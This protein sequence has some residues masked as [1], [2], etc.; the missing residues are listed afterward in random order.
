VVEASH[1]EL[2]LQGPLTAITA[3]LVGV[4]ANLALFFAGPLLWPQGAIGP[5]D[6]PALALILL[7]CWLL[8]A[9]R[10]SV[11]RLIA[12][13]ALVGALITPLRS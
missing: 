13:A 1:G 12:V 2:S 6:F 4:I 9:H 5:F 7:A 8:I 11:L 3:E 10:W